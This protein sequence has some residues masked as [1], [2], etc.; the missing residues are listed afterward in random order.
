MPTSGHVVSPSLDLDINL[1]VVNSAN[2]V[3]A[4]VN[5]EIVNKELESDSNTLLTVDKDEAANADM[6]SI[7]VNSPL[8]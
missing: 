1:E 7:D 2:G 5:E 6:A 4:I 3:N 8:P